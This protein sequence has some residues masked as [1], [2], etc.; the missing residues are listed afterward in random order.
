MPELSFL[1]LMGFAMAEVVVA[2]AHTSVS[3]T[4]LS[5]EV[6]AILVHLWSLVLAIP[7]IQ[8]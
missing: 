2:L 5:L 3:F 7:P 8:W 1:L 6:M 4:L